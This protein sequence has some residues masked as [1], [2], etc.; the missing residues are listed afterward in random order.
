MTGTPDSDYPSPTL[1]QLLRASEWLQ[2]APRMSIAEFVDAK[3][4]LKGPTAAKWRL[5]MSVAQASRGAMDMWNSCKKGSDPQT[6]PSAE[7]YPRPIPSPLPPVP[8]VDIAAASCS[9]RLG[10]TETSDTSDEGDASWMNFLS[11]LGQEALLL[12]RQ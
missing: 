6:A 1:P 3:L 2:K 7:A 10:F 5:G 12:E 11:P 9:T 4:R 8:D